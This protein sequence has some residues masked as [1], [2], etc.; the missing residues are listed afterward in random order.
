MLQTPALKV[1]TKNI[2]AYGGKRVRGRERSA[3]R[4][5]TNP[6]VGSDRTPWSRKWR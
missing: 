4:A 2:G 6:G 1:L 5:R 3:V